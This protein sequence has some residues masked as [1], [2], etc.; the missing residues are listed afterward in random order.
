M[1]AHRIDRRN[2]LTLLGGAIAAVTLLGCGAT[3]GRLP[4]YRYRLTVE[5]D[6][7]E[8]LKTG[9]SVIEVKTA[10]AGRN[11]IPTPGVISRRA[12]GEAVTVDLGERGILFALLRSEDSSDWAS[13]V[14]YGFAPDVPQPHD[15]NGEF[16][17]SAYFKAR[18]MAMLKKRKLIVLPERFPGSRYIEGGHARP[19]LVRF[20][21]IADPQT[22]EKVDSA[23]LAAAFG[24]GVK[25]KR[26]TVQLTDDPVTAGI[27]KRLTWLPGVYQTVDRTHFQPEGIPVGDFQHLFSTKEF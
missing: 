5:V 19:M 7:P 22:I 25:L 6:T 12:H 15:E 3:G 26:I 10:V 9:S 17:S 1:T 23:D 8:G 21:D 13:G 16:D 20:R 14:M 11:S 18:F 27:E 2:V 24:S 4:D